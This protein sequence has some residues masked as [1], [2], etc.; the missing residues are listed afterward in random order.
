[1]FSFFISGDVLVI[2]EPLTGSEGVV[3]IV[4]HGQLDDVGSVMATGALPNVSPEGYQVKKVTFKKASV[5][6]DTFPSVLF[7]T[8]KKSPVT[9]LTP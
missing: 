4:Q 2:A 5:K 7:D 9:F 1:M 6:K 3:E 8:L